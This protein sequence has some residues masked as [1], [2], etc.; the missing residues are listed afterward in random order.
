ML[1]REA[2]ELRRLSMIRLGRR[3]LVHMHQR[4]RGGDTPVTV[5][6]GAALFDPAQQRTRSIQ[7]LM[8]AA[9]QALYQAR[10]TAAIA[11][12][13]RSTRSLETL[14][15][16]LDEHFQI[17]R[18]CG[19]IYWEGSHWTRLQHAVDAALYESRGHVG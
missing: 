8:R 11:S 15:F 19:R 4:T 16:V 12:R 9:D 17:C 2:D 1:G 14:R 18:D 7:T 5:S 10:R 6:V 3:L 13:S